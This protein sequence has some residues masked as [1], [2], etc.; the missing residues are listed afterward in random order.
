MKK[1]YVEDLNI[2]E[3]EDIVIIEMPKNK[4]WVLRVPLTEEEEASTMMS[5]CSGI[6]Y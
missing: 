2:A 4:D 3:G 5:E 1:K 6:S